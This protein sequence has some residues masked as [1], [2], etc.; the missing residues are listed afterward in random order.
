M[1]GIFY[2]LCYGIILQ[3]NWDEQT[4]TRLRD[5]EIFCFWLKDSCHLSSTS[6]WTE[7][8]FKMKCAFNS[9]D[10]RYHFKV[11]VA[12]L[13]VV[14]VRRSA[15]MSPSQTHWSGFSE[16]FLHTFTVHVKTGVFSQRSVLGRLRLIKTPVRAALMSRIMECLSSDLHRTKTTH[17]ACGVSR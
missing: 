15:R 17:R 7:Q 1:K 10:V 5:P 11:I 6:A 8:R 4:D 13:D 3:L 2:C 12:L 14:Q 9:Y 16:R